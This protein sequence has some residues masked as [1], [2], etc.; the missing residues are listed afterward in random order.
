MRILR[1]NG[2]AGDHPDGLTARCRDDKE[3]ATRMVQEPF[4]NSAAEGVRRNRR[5]IVD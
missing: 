4:Q 2:A 5:D 1:A 3:I